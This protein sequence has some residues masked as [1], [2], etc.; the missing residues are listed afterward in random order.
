MSRDHRCHTQGRRDDNR[1]LSS[2]SSFSQQPPSPPPQEGDIF[3]GEIVK[4]ESYGAFCSLFGTRW[5][6]LIHISQL[7]DSRV[8]HVDDV[9]SLNDRVWVKVIQ[10]EQPQKR[11]QSDP[12]DRPPR[13]RIKLSMKDVSQDGSR[14]DLGQRRDDEQQ[15]KTQLET[16]L[17]SMIGV[18]V[19]RDPMQN[20][21]LILKGIGNAANKTAMTFRGGYTLVGDDEGEV[22]E[23]QSPINRV[24]DT[25]T[26]LNSKHMGRGRGATLPAWMTLTPINDGPIGNKK[27]E[28]KNQSSDSDDSDIKKDKKTRKRKRLKKSSRKDQ[29]RRSNKRTKKKHGR[30]SREDFSSDCGDGDNND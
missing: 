7:H 22:P 11:F 26:R 28:S 4:I 3:Q 8:E 23:P 19:A 2:M 29:K 10:V 5:Q 15:V 25:G 13:L 21:R 30:Q 20:Q 1:N 27:E 14:Q 12:L 9:V 6:G 18:A 17:N 16:N 24:A